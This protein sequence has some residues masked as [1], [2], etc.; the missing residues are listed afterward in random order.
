MSCLARW[1]TGSLCL[2]VWLMPMLAA[3]HPPNASHGQENGAGADAPGNHGMFMIGSDT[4]YLV[5]MPMLTHE[6]HMYQ[7]VLEVR[8][9]ASVMR[10]YQRL[11]K[12]HPE[13]AYNL[14]N[15]ED[16]KFTLPDLKSGEV[17]RFNATVFDGYTNDGGGEPGPVIADNVPVVIKDVVVYRHFDFAIERPEHLIYTLFGNSNETHLVHYIARDPDFQH[18]MTWQSAPKAFSPAQ[19]KSGVELSFPALKSMPL[20]CS[21][22][23][24]ARLHDVLFQ[25][26]AEAPLQLD[27][28]KGLQQIWYS[29]GNLLNTTDPCAPGGESGEH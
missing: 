16:N 18:I 28:R 13:T 19:L 22:P 10:D 26:R 2:L 3:A 6:K 7:L 5:H 9:P 20:G 1:V 24:T 12:E 23:V 8:L 27:L 25:G 21:P 15:V 11:R 4:L 14:I 29:T 17:R